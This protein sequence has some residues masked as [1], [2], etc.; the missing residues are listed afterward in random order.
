MINRVKD[1]RLQIAQA[2]LPLLL[3]PVLLVIDLPQKIVDLLKQ[4]NV[5]VSS[6]EWYWQ[7]LLN[8][9]NWAIIIVVLPYIY[10]IIR[11]HNKDDVLRQTIPHAIV[12]H[13]YPGYWFCRYILNY[14][15]VSLTRMPIPVQFQ[16]VWKELF[17][18]TIIW[19]M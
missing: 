18:N 4:A 2:I 17:K 3:I 11:K 12:W 7:L 1:W 8:L 5:D 6:L 14:Q 15:T 9:G 10:K 19:I 16:L 13:S